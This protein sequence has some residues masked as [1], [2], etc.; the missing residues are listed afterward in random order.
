MKLCQD[1]LPWESPLI[2]SPITPPCI[3]VVEDNRS[4]AVLLETTLRSWG[5]EVCVGR[6]GQEGLG[7]LTIHTVDVI[8]LD[9]EMPVMD[10]RTM[11][12]EVQLAGYS[13]PVWVMSGGLNRQALSPLLAEGAQGFL[14]KPFGL[15]ALEQAL[16]QIFGPS[17]SSVPLNKTEFSL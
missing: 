1:N 13:M 5:Y 11:L 10:G 3:L 12:K 2:R 8:F 6:N 16:G 15:A 7:L 17:L 14:M 9:L 4:V